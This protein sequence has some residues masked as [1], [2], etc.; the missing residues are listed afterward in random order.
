MTV[1]PEAAFLLAVLAPFVIVIAL[2][3]AI[4]AID[5]LIKFF[6]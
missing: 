5:S 2:Y 6:K 1:T 3:L 4:E